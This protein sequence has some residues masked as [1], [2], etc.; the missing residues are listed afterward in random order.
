MHVFQNIL[1]PF[2]AHLRNEEVRGP[3][4][5]FKAASA[6]IAKIMG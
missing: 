6:E 1:V 4:N 3:R 2:P 5:V